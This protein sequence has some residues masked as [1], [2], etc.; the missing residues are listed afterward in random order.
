[1]EVI[2]LCCYGTA[3]VSVAGRWHMALADM[4]EASWVCTGAK[5]ASQVKEW[6][7]MVTECCVVLYLLGKPI[8][9]PG[10]SFYRFRQGVNMSRDLPSCLCWL[11]CLP[12]HSLCVSRGQL[13]RRLGVVILKLRQS[14]AHNCVPKSSRLG[15]QLRTS[16]C[17][18]GDLKP[19][20]RWLGG[21]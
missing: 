16:Q 14:V 18:P 13:M 1:M 20:K 5:V 6:V 7:V 9:G 15:I 3:S 4:P 10:F 12:A 17:E 11:W 2:L 8:L 21:H 19:H